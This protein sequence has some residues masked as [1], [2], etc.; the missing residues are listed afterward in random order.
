MSD[1]PKI[2][3]I[4]DDAYL[5]GIYARK[6]EQ[7]QCEVEVID[8][9]AE[10]RKKYKKIKPDAIV[11]DAA[12]ENESGFEFIEEVRKTRGFKKVPVIVITQLGDRRSVKLGL[13]KGA[14]DY[15]IKGH[16]VPTEAAKKIKR[17]AYAKAKK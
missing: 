17:L 14:T 16:F 5:A 3:I 10:A 7:E 8:N 13:E 1:K 6:L 15:L 12:M 9:L 4:E 2:L 11:L